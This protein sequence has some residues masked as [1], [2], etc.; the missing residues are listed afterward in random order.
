[1]KL[2]TRYLFPRVSIAK[3]ALL[4]ALLVP[5]LLAGISPAVAQCAPTSGPGNDVSVCNSGSSGPLTDLSG[6]NTLTFAPGGSGEINGNVT[7]GA[8]NDRIEMHSG[9][10]NGDVNQ[11]DGANT[12][13]ISAGAVNGDVV[14]GGGV[15]SFQMTGGL[16]ES[17][18]QGGSL[19][20]FFMSGG[21]IVGLFFAGDDVT[22]TGGRIGDVNLEQANN[23]MRMSGGI[24]DQNVRAVQ[25]NDRLELSGGVI[26]GFVNLGNGS[27]TV[28]VTGG[29][30]GGDVITFGANPALHG[31]NVV[32]ISG[33]SIGGSVLTGDGSDTFTWQSAGTIGGSVQLGAGQDTATLRNLTESTLSSVAVIDGGSGVDVNSG[34]GTD[35]L[36]FDATSASAVSRYTNWENVS[37]TNGSAFTL[38]GEFV[39]GDAITQTGTFNIDSSSTLFAG[40]AGSAIS[41]FAAGQLA[42]LTNSG[43]IDLTNAAGPASAFTVNGNYIGNGGRLLLETQLGSDGSPS[44]KLVISAGTASG[45][46]GIVVTNVG[47]TGAQTVANG[48]LLV[49]TTNGGATQAGAFALSE[50]V[51]AGAYEYLLFRGGV[52]TG[53]EQNWYLRS[54]LVFPPDPSPSAPPPPAPIPLYRPEVPINAALP[55]L[56]H[57]VA[58]ATLGTFHE[59]RG[60]QSDATGKNPFA[61][62]WG[63]V[64]GE[65]S[66][67]GWSGAIAPSF[68][69][70]L[71]GI[72]TGVDLLGFDRDNGH[73]DRAGLFFAYARMSGDIRGFSVGI[74]DNRAGNAALE[75]TSLGTYWTHIGPGNG[76]LDGVAMVTWFSSN[77]DASGIDG[78]DPNGTGVT[79]SLEGGY[80]IVL[81]GG[82][83]LEPQAQIVWRRIDLE[84]TR[85]SF[86]VITFDE[87]DGVTGRLG[88]RLQGSSIPA[89]ATLIAPY[90]KANIW[91]DFGGDDTVAFDAD[92]FTTKRGG[93]SLEL[94][95][96]FNAAI[97]RSTTLHASGSYVTDIGGDVDREGV[98]GTLGLQVKW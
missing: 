47:G 50:R 74:P 54:T 95:A 1:M 89:G 80:P 68:D 3:L 13:I 67:L 58:M 24:I 36:I 10:I 69:G 31:N 60:E 6:N 82:W 79:L 11:G 43:T 91:H 16:I 27:D 2:A 9:A 33:G 85:D 46:T 12:F 97:S 17:L 28:I 40:A 63:R 90:F 73:R 49:E 18:S 39:L 51:A 62:T 78:A 86:S 65:R 98:E 59:R 34:L 23:V 32:S 84:S 66:D 42:T 20:T 71:F 44:D 7:F 83:R 22:I 93:T 96:G 48:I 70:N 30:I 38:D 92:G 25:G 61:P 77:T 72:Q 81:I 76:Y 15:D 53:S 94:G 8:G 56:A 52:T 55:P 14:Q 29:S 41:P 5:P 75:G 88:F 45:T 57:E 4:A 21:R 19:D 37:L 87:D 35:S 64:F 26:N